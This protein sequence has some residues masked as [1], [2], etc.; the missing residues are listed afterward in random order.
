MLPVDKVIKRVE[1]MT[2]IAQFSTEQAKIY[3]PTLNQLKLNFIGQ[4]QPL[5][6]Q[7]FM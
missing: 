7:V 1:N 6:Y 3:W 2:E 5:L 4:N